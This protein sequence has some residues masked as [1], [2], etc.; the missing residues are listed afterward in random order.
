M[1]S[2]SF[3]GKPSA[4]LQETLIADPLDPIGLWLSGVAAQERGEYK[5]ALAYWYQL[6][7]ILEKQPD[8]SED[9]IAVI[10]YAEEMVRSEKAPE[11][12]QTIPNSSGKTNLLNSQKIGIE[13]GQDVLMTIDSNK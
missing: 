3:L 4:L 1:S 8:S 9:L 13:I 5:E 7:P 10:K 11:D 12:S 6:K 2:G